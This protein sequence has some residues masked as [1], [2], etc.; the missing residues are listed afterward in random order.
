MAE[1]EV[2]CQIVVV[3][4]SS[5][6]RA[7][8]EASKELSY[9]MTGGFKTQSIVFRDGVLVY[10]MVAERTALVPSESLKAILNDLSRKVARQEPEDG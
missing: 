6:R 10:T 9:L 8:D 5:G 2:R 4:L 1:T 7:L 3:H